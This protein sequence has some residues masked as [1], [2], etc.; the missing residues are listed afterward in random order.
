MVTRSRGEDAAEEK[1]GR[2]KAG[3][4]ERWENEQTDGQVKR[5]RKEKAG[6]AMVEPR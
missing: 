3:E 5:E 4:A 1:G 2:L 6:C